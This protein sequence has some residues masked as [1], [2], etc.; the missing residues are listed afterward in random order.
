MLGLADGDSPGDI[1]GVASG[2]PVGEMV[3]E[4]VG[5]GEGYHVSCSGQLFG[6]KQAKR[7]AYGGCQPLCKT[8]QLA[9]KVP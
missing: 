6:T 5:V 4:R 1:V 9:Q 2:E 8:S 7:L 3:G